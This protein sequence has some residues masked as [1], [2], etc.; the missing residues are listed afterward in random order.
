MGFIE[1]QMTQLLVYEREKNAQTVH[2]HWLMRSL[3]G[4][5]RG[6]MNYLF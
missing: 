1:N 3:G 2:Q 4:K 6:K 5:E